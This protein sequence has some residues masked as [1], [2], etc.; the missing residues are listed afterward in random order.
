MS[1]RLEIDATINQHLAAIVSADGHSGV[2]PHWYLQFNY[3]RRRGDGRG[4]NQEALNCQLVR[5]FLVAV[6]KHE[7]Q[8]RASGIM[9]VLEDG[10]LGEQRKLD[11]LRV[12]KLGLMQDR[13]TGKV[14]VRV[15]ETQMESA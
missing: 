6:P 10:E 4:S 9:Q 13:L 1:T 8:L 14:P 7:E 2:Y 11:T 3:E 12:K 15:D 5:G